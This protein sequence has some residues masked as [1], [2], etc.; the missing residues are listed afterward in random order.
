MTNIFKGKNV[1][2]TGGTGSIGSH[3]VRRLFQYRPKVVRVFS[4]D[5]NGLF[6]LEQELQ[7]Y[8]NVRYLMGDIKDKE[9]LQRAVEGIDFIFH[10]A[11]LKHVPLCEY[12][13]FEAAKTNV[14]GTQNMIDVA[15]GQEIEKF[16]TI[17]TDKAVNP[18]NVMG[19][20]KLLAE[21][22]TIS[23][24]YYKGV[25]KTA[26][27]CV[28]FGNV[29][30][31]RGS[32]VPLFQSQIEKGGPVTLTDPNMTRF[33]MSIPKAVDLVLRAAEMAQG[34][35]IFIFKMPVVRISDLA[36][37]VITELAP[38]YGFIPKSVR[39]QIVGKRPGEKDYE[40]L[41]TEDEA[42]IARET[43]DMFII[44]PTVR[45]RRGKRTLNKAYTSKTGKPL[46]KKAIKELLKENLPEFSR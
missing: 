25:R 31:S 28:R 38:R 12:N 44:S 15:M 39:V 4:N 34:G 24:N 21:R 10:C 32:V 43:E 13:P 6:T 36:D 30:D 7:S 35:E 3:I 8:S 5:E 29:L 14:F 16:V 41:L 42:I 1:L 27:S 18:V 22:L 17:S 26:F 33:V 23:A 45:G 11:A 19:A 37:V 46:S 40:E 9:R 20:T 2:V